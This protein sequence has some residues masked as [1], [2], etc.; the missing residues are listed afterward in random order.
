[1]R[2]CCTIQ[3]QCR[4]IHIHER[5]YGKSDTTRL[6][7]HAMRHIRAAAAAMGAYGMTAA[8]GL[9]AVFDT[10]S[11]R[12]SANCKCTTGNLLGTLRAPL[13]GVLEWIEE[14]II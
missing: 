12:A 6:D 4:E 5:E 1:M 9:K 3:E 2:S 11:A 8:V 10:R 13:S 14:K 7:V